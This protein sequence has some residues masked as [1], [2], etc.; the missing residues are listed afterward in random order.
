[1]CLLQFQED[2]EELNKVLQ[3]KEEEIRELSEVILHLVDAS[4]EER[5]LFAEM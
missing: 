5:K 1:M 2:T 3:E 4:E